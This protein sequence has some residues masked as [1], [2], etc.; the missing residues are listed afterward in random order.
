MPVGVYSTREDVGVQLRVFDLAE[1]FGQSFAWQS[2]GPL[3]TS[4]IPADI[5]PVVKKRRTEWPPRRPDV[6]RRLF[7]T[8]DNVDKL[9]LY[10]F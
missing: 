10:V 3:L 6:V 4:F 9:L 5:P 2:L 7:T 8:A 1:V